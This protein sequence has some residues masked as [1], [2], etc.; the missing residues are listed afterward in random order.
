MSVKV[1][2]VNTW[3]TPKGV[4][5]ENITRVCRAKEITEGKQEP[6]LASAARCSPLTPEKE[7]Q[8]KE[9]CYHITE[10]AGDAEAGPLIWAVVTEKGS[11]CQNPSKMSKYPDLPSHIASPLSSSN[12]QTQLEATWPWSLRKEVFRSQAF[13]VQNMAGKHREQIWRETENKDIP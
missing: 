8:G 5:A 11:L 9:G 7:R 6:E 2:A 1:P 13:K 10:A 3:H 4:I 12:F